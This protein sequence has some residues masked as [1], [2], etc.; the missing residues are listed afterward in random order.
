[1]APHSNRHVTEFSPFQSQN[2]TKS[3]KF[4]RVRIGYRF[5]FADVIPFHHALSVK[6][7]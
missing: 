3:H 7:E 6:L 4:Q 5:D 1:V 2:F